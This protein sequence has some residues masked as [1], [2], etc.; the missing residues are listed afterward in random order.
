MGVCVFVCVCERES[1]RQC[2]HEFLCVLNKNIYVVRYGNM[3][4]ED[5]H[6]FWIEISLMIG[7]DLKRN[8]G[9]R[10]LEI[11]VRLHVKF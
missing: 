1:E 9:I 5:S 6:T 7:D 8:A 11:P 3:N 2:V 4:I 10:S